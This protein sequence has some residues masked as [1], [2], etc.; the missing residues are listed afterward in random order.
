MQI[1][2]ASVNSGSTTDIDTLDICTNYDVAIQ[3]YTIEYLESE[4]EL[5]SWANYTFGMY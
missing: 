5:E 1:L 2:Q 3:T 4:P